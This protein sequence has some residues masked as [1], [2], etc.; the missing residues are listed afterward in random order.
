[1]SNC[2]LK[3]FTISK[4][5]K[6][7]TDR[8]VTSSEFGRWMMAYFSPNVYQ[9]LLF[10][11]GKEGPTY[12]PGTKL[13]IWFDKQGNRF[14]SEKHY[15]IYIPTDTE[16]YARLKEKGIVQPKDTS[17]NCKVAGNKKVVRCFTLEQIQ[18]FLDSF[19]NFNEEP[20]HIIRVKE[21][22]SKNINIS[23]TYDDYKHYICLYQPKKVNLIEQKP[24]IKK[25]MTIE[26]VEKELGYSI[27]IVSNKE[28]K[29]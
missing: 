23:T 9:E 12:H 19:V 14:I 4:G 10:V 8:L 16:T 28:E 20:N 18:L 17:T 26:Q 11:N 24:I 1:M 6:K 3:T 29:E 7:V 15:S 21:H 22:L 25:Q 5:N 2:K 27:A 13:G